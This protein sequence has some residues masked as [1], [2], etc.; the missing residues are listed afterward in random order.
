M[1]DS[2]PPRATELLYLD[3]L[4]IGQ[5]FTS[6]AYSLDDDMIKSFA[7]EFDPQP[8]HLDGQAA[9]ETLFG[10]LAASG[11]HTAAI[12]MRLLVHRLPLAGGVIGAGAEVTWPRPARPGFELHVE[13]AVTEI[14]PSRSNPRRGIVTV[15]TETRN[16]HGDVVQLLISKL[17]VP[18]RG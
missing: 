11:W 8:F 2:Q 9:Q 5:R 6:E 18:R 14:R 10:G 15:R 4:Q 3:D 13:S 16:Q 17:V 12:P 1:T 7:G